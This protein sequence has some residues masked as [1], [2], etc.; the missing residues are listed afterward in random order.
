MLWEIEQGRLAFWHRAEKCFKD[1]GCKADT[2]G[3]FFEV[4]NISFVL[5]R[6]PLQKWVH[7]TKYPFIL[8]AEKW[9]W[10]RSD[11]FCEYVI[12][13][14]ALVG[15]SQLLTEPALSRGLDITFFVILPYGPRMQ[16]NEIF[17]FIT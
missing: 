13:F 3:S 12:Q 6:Q 7:Q 15:K 4:N 8:N 10:K 2:A 16:K 14:T 9:K 5:L 17:Q 1:N 11:K